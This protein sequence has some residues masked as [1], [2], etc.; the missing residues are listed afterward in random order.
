MIFKKKL[1][2]TTTRNNYQLLS[3]VTETLSL[4]NIE[5]TN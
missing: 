3:Q 5:C 4:L 1:I 2:C